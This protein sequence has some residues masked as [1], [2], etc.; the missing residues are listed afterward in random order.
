M[1]VTPLAMANAY[2]TFAAHGMHCQPRV[3]LEIRDRTNESLP[4]PPEK[5]EQ[6]VEPNIADT[7]TA[8]LTGVIDG[9]IQGRT[10][11]AMSLPDRPAAGKTG[12]TNESA[13]VWFCGFTPDIAAAVWVGDP[14]GGFGYPMKDVTVNGKYYS[15]VFGGTLPGP[16]WQQAMESALAGTLPTDFVLTADYGLRPARGLSSLPGLIEVE[17]GGDV[18]TFDNSNADGLDPNAPD[19]IP[20][21]PAAPIEPAPEVAPVPVTPAPAAPVVPTPTPTG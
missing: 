1:E 18:F 9:P 20:V 13:A 16:I 8:L 10:G 3:I 11:G 19:P 7:V 5:C 14:R 2:A 6:V 17:T 4:V 21:D 15:Q 12:T